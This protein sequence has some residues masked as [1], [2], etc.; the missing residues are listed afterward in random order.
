M[1]FTAPRNTGIPLHWAVR[2]LAL[3]PLACGAGGPDCETRTAHARLFPDQTLVEWTIEACVV[4]GEAHPVTLTVD[5]RT[6]PRGDPVTP[7]EVVA[8]ERDE[9]GQRVEVHGADNLS[10]ITF[11]ADPAVKS[12]DV[13][14]GRHQGFTTSV[15]FTP[16][17]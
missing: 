1:P 2:A 9:A 3:T 15:K 11:D 12:L 7:V 14:V 6:V 4:C 10:T 8:L 13:A 17:E 16:G 5:G